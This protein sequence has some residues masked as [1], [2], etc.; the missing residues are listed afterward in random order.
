M[1]H[2][3]IHKVFKA[4]GRIVVK[5]ITVPAKAIQRGAE[6]TMTAAILG[7]IRHLL[8][9]GGGYLWTGDDLSQFVGA[10]SVIV[11]LVWSLIDKHRRQA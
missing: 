2:V 3:K 9:M 4:I 7:I 8:T 10:A 6:K 5:P 1:R 11:G